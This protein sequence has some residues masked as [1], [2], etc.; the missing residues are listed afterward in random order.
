MTPKETAQQLLDK[1]FDLVKT[2]KQQKKC[3]LIT[4]NEVIN[5]LNTDDISICQYWNE[6]K[7]EIEN[8]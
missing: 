6:V 5:Q 3:A 4:I 1:Y 8:L 2:L 7:Q